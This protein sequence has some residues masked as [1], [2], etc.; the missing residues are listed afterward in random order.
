M[1]APSRLD[2]AKVTIAELLDTR[3]LVVV[4]QRLGVDPKTL[5]RWRDNE[6]VPSGDNLQTLARFFGVDAN[7][8]DLSEAVARTS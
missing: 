7:Q 8:I 5:R 2:P 6:V 4:A 1:D 3:N